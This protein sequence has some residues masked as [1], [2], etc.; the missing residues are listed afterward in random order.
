MLKDV[1]A[2]VTSRTG[3]TSRD[4]LLREINFAWKELW[5][6]DDI[7]NSLFEISVKPIDNQARITLPWYV[8]QIRAVKQN[9]GRIR[10]HLN[11]PRP[12]YQDETFVQSLWV[13]RVLGYRPMYKSISNATTVD[14]TIA[15]VETATFKVVLRGPTDNAQDSRE[16]LVFQPGDVTK[17]STLRFTDLISITKDKLTESNVTIADSLG[18]EIG[19]IPNCSFEAKNTIVQITDKC[20]RVCTDCLCFDILYKAP[21]PYLYYDDTTILYEEVLMAKTLEWMTLPKDGQEKKATLYSEKAATL[22]AQFN[23]N[24]ASTEKKL[25]VGQNLYTTLYRGYL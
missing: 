9:W 1:I 5:N 22:L 6:S 8:D 17:Q 13:W 4:I 2:F 11:T 16:E 21:C 15:K 18:E 24:E 20:F 25:D 12:Y 3:E 10:I 19:L 7:P 14:I 23:T